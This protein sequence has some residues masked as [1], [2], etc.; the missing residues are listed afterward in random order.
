MLV[1]LTAIDASDIVGYLAAA[2]RIG[3]VEFSNVDSLVKGVR[4]RVAFGSLR[5]LNILDHG[6]P[7]GIELGTDWIDI[8][9]LPLYRLKLSQLAG[10]FGPGGFVHLQH[11]EAG[12]NHLLL[13]ILSAIFQVPVYAG[14]GAHNAVYRFNLGRYDRCIPSDSCDSDVERPD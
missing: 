3:E 7:D 6:N 4:S 2:T 1:D 11:C 10:L 8:S 14:T 5:R 13:S 9:S 12:Q